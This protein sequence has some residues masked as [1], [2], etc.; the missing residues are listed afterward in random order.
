M[1]RLFTP[2]RGQADDAVVVGVDGQGLAAGFPGEPLFGQ[3]HRFI[4]LGWTGVA[5]QTFTRYL[6]RVG[7]FMRFPV[8]DPL[9]GV[10][11]QVFLKTDVA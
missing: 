6:Q 1:G 8:R 4:G 9:I 7:L 2:H 10:I 5:E 11:G 3:L